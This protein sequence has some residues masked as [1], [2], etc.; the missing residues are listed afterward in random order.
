MG[1][2]VEAR[3]VLGAPVDEGWGQ[4]VHD[5]IEGIQYGGPVSVSSGSSAYTVGTWVVVT[6][7][8]TFVAAP[9]VFLTNASGSVVL[10]VSVRNVTTTQMEL[11]A[12]RVDGNASPATAQTHWLAVG[13]AA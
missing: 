5:N 2:I 12:V 4:E 10:L 9:K 11:G 1:N 6:F 8:R 13:V 7:P 3:P